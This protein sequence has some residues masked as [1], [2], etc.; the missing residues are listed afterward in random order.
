MKEVAILMVLGLILNYMISM[1][2]TLLKKR[3]R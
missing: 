1:V 2:L 3:I